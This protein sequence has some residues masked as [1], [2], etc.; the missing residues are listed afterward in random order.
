MF[1]FLPGLTFTVNFLDLCFWNFLC[2]AI[3][4]LQIDKHPSRRAGQCYCCGY[5]MVLSH[6]MSPHTASQL[7][8]TTADMNTWW[9]LENLT[10][11]SY[12]E[13]PNSLNVVSENTHC[14][15]RN[16]LLVAK[17][18]KV[19]PTGPQRDLLSDEPTRHGEPC[20]QQ[21]QAQ[22]GTDVH[23]LHSLECRYIVFC[24]ND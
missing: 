4:D 11:A 16:P 23:D 12:A 22:Q 18:Q 14:T 9:D 8:F 19:P 17:S 20:W 13:G 3:W 1:G 5:N 21:S 24:P 7:T 6:T 10:V 15:L 2:K